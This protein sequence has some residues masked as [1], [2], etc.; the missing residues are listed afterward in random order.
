MKNT[1]ILLGNYTEQTYNTQGIVGSEK[2]ETGLYTTSYQYVAGK[3]LVESV[4]TPNGKNIEYAYDTEDNMTEM[5]GTVNGTE[6]ANYMNYQFGELIELNHSVNND[7]IN[8]EYEKKRRLSA[9]KFGTSVYETIAYEDKIT[10]DGNVVDRMTLT[11]AKGEVFTAV[12]DRAG[13]FEKVYYKQSSTANDTLILQKGYNEYGQLTSI[14]DHL[15][16]ETVSITYDSVGQMTRY[17]SSGTS[18]LTETYTYDY[19]GNLQRLVST[20]VVS[21]T[22]IFTYNSNSQGNLTQITTGSFICALGYDTYNRCTSET[23]SINGGATVDTKTMTYRKEDAH[24]TSMVSQLQYRNGTRLAYTYDSMGNIATV[25]KND[26]L[27]ARYTYDGLNRLV[28]EDNQELNTTC[29]YTYDGN[30]NMLSKE[31]F[32][33]TTGSVTS[34]TGMVQSYFY[35]NRDQLQSYN[36]QIFAY[37][38]VGNPTMY[39]G[40]TLTWTKGRK[41]INFNGTTFTYDAQGKRIRKNSTNYYYNSAGQLL[42]SSDGMEYFYGNNG[43]MGFV[44]SGNKYIYRKNLQGDVIEILDSNGNSVVQYVY[45]A[46]GSCTIGSGGNQTLAQIN[47]FRYRSYFYDVETGLYFLKTRYYDSTI[48]RFINID[49]I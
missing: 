10:V 4:T 37:D 8:Y 35:N 38:A 11:N 22:D 47:P 14:A 46:W 20:G 27:V 13:T 3:K 18:T 39:K 49:S 6:N 24:G 17:A 19:R 33:Y 25:K 23:I 36:G 43:V 29:L 28:R 15:S 21:R 30:G 48:A 31:T 7:Y 5:S 26:V 9:V 45:D 44:Y 12:A 40:Q 42:K 1:A 32:A 16:N 34:G 41:L 2:D